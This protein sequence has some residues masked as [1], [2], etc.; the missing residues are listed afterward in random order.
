MATYGETPVTG[1]K[2][3]RCNSIMINNSYQQI[4]YISV[5][6]EELISLDNGT[7]IPIFNTN[8]NKQFNPSDLIPLRDPATDALTGASISQKEVYDIMY[9]FYRQIAGG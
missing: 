7:C 8:Y 2:W 5:S 3:K 6:E 4:P 9:S 1:T